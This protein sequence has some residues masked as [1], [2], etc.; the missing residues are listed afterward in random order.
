MS[1]ELELSHKAKDV[2]LPILGWLDLSFEC[3]AAVQMWDI[4]TLYTMA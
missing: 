2:G 3:Y 4:H 1:N